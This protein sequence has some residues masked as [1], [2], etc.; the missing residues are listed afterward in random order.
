M[1]H[2]PI[3]ISKEGK[4]IGGYSRHMTYTII[5][6]MYILEIQQSYALHADNF[7][8]VEQDGKGIQHSVIYIDEYFFLQKCY[9]FPCRNFRVRCNNISS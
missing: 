2:G 1:L 3:Q 5:N 9:K 6:N 8:C 4:M 7:M